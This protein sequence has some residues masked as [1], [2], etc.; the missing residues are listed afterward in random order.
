MKLNK[1]FKKP[2]AW[3][4]AFVALWSG[5]ALY[6]LYVAEAPVLTIALVGLTSSL[7]VLK[8]MRSRSRRGHYPN[9]EY[10]HSA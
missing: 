10:R 2:L 4:W 8:A 9:E 1:L 6:G 3:A 7:L 5:H